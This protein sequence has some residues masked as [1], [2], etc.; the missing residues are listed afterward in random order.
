LPW[1]NAP[2]YRGSEMVRVIHPVPRLRGTPA[3]RIAAVLTAL[4]VVAPSLGA[5]DCP[6]APSVRVHPVRCHC[7]E[8]RTATPST[9]ALTASVCA[10]ACRMAPAD[11]QVADVEIVGLGDPWSAAEPAAAVQA[12]AP[13]PAPLMPSVAA[14]PPPVLASRSRTILRI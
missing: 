8:G 13:D 10:T 1:T 7:C 6:V 11:R 12:I 4:A 14:S 5:C 9:T 3:S 2:C